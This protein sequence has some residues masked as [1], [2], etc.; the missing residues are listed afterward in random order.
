M[1]A[2][3]LF[4]QNFAV[5]ESLVQLY[6][7][8][9]GLSRS[10]LSKDLHLAICAHWRAPTN[11][12]VQ[13]ASNDRV[14]VLARSVTRIPESLTIDGGLDF[15][16]RQAVVV[17]CTCVESFFWDALRENV[18]TIVQ[19][20]KTKADESLRKLTLTLEQYISIQQYEDPDFRLQQI[21]LANFER[22]TLYDVGQIDGI[23]QIMTVQ[24]FGRR[25][26]ESRG[27]PASQL[28]QLVQD[29]INRRNQI[30]HRADR[31]GEGE[32]ADGH[33]LRPITYPGPMC[34]CRQPAHWLLPGPKSFD[35]SYRL[36]SDLQ[37][38][39]ETGRILA[40][41]RVN[42]AATENRSMKP[43]TVDCHPRY[44]AQSTRV[45]DDRNQRA[46]RRDLRSA[47]ERAV[48][49]RC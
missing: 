13:H 16:L 38:P 3:T 42:A 15:L 12:V 47:A 29:L 7:L 27:R 9:H 45:A 41:W 48:Q 20:R 44:D 40:A 10:D 11:T 32:E 34:E 2:L 36:G 22:G 26:K 49:T 18:L 5:A 17:A 30:A 39:N 37:A 19:A 46:A 1:E 35:A 31:P 24:N 8:F 28:K 23:A 21:I 43:E 33:G 4:H 14:S 25:L 6:Q